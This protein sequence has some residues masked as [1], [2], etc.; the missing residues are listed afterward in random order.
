MHDIV[1]S[2]QATNYA[3]S[4]QGFCEALLRCDDR[5]ACY[6]NNYY[7]GHVR[8]LEN[9]F[10]ATFR[11]LH[12]QDF[13]ALAQVY[14]EHYPAVSWDINLFGEHFSELIAAQIQSGRSSHYNWATI[15]AVAS[16]EYGISSVYYAQERTFTDK[17]P[18][19]IS[20]GKDS[21]DSSDIILCLQ[22][23]HPYADITPALKFS[24]TIALWRKEQ[25][26]KI[27]NSHL[28]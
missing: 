19:R 5:L 14:V 17:T 16:I 18:Y 1:E 26:I 28:C 22:Q 25:R 20:V 6:S 7:A 27:S 2:H 24:L 12:D 15:A 9:T 11:L 4:L 3:R 10:P 23:Q 21:V 8:A 13:S